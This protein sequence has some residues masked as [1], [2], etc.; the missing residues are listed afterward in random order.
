MNIISHRGYSAKAP[1]NTISSVKRSLESNLYGIEV[2]VRLTKD[3]VPLLLHDKSLNRTTNVSGYLSNYKYSDLS[4]ISAGSW[5]SKK[6]VNERVPY[7]GDVIQLINAQ[8]RLIIDTK[9]DTNN[10]KHLVEIIIKLIKKYHAY[11]WIEVQSID[12]RILQYV[13]KTDKKVFTRLYIPVTI[14]YTN[15][16]FTNMINTNLLEP[17][18]YINAYNIDFGITDSL[19]SKISSLG[20]KLILGAAAPISRKFIT[21]YKHSPLIEGVMRNDPDQFKKNIY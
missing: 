13:K 18:K 7:L 12:K 15:I 10:W 1:E 20:L 21:K 17:E 5:F 2:D 3:N 6:F 4:K 19:I 16:Y 14:P 8:S 11:S 9:L